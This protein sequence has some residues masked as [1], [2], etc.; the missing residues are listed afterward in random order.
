MWG[1]KLKAWPPAV[2]HAR[3]TAG[4]E[5]YASLLLLPNNTGRG[6][7]ASMRLYVLRA[8]PCRALPSPPAWRLV[9]CVVGTTPRSRPSGR[10][11]GR[12]APPRFSCVLGLDLAWLRTLKIPCASAHAEVP[13]LRSQLQFPA[14]PLAQVAHFVLPTSALFSPR[15]LWHVGRQL[16]AEA[17]AALVGWLP[18]L[19]TAA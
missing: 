19:A 7:Y 10:S 4:P 3:M 17:R 15:M 8:C 16:L 18:G 9:P 6:V 12:A 11:A 1:K 5:R 2:A 13:T 14:V